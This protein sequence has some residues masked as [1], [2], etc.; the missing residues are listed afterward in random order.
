MALTLYELV[1]RDDRRFSPYCWRARFALAHK[2]LDYDVVPCRF[3][4]KD[5]IAFS[6]Q[7]RVPV[8]DDGGETLADSW[9]I[10]CHLEDAYPDGPSLFGGAV[11]RGEALFLN[12]WADRVLHPRLIRLV[13]KD[14]FDHVAPADREYFR[15]S[16][17]KRFGARLEDMHAERD[18][19]LPAAVDALAPLGTVLGTQPF[20]CGDAPAYGDYIVF[21]AFQW[22]RCISD[23][24]IVEPD[25]PVHA[26]R[27]RMLD[28]HGG[29][30]R[31]VPAYP[32]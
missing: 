12:A 6:G 18:R 2:G 3:T 19:H 17:E 28:L 1:G 27:E 9:R 7:G 20:V 4:D 30:A 31:S 23:Y 5:R 8:L 22:C 32:V 15:D 29:L 11:G 24:R 10:A 26:W 14:I 21:G 13:I 16:R 25:G